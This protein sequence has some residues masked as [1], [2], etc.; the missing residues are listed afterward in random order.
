MLIH[1]ESDNDNNWPSKKYMNF[2]FISKNLKLETTKATNHTKN[3]ASFPTIFPIDSQTINYS[4]KSTD[5]NITYTH[6]QHGR[7]AN[8][9]KTRNNST[10]CETSVQEPVSFVIYT[11]KQM[12]S[13]FSFLLASTTLFPLRCC[14]CASLTE[15]V[16]LSLVYH[17][18]SFFK[19]EIKFDVIYQE[20]NIYSMSHGKNPSCLQSNF[21]GGFLRDFF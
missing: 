14:R 1:Q 16:P 13:N 5:N 9:M 19:V 2:H 8:T 3:A 11:L 7:E 10:I 12:L 18:L 15:L 21:C 17:C 20:G 4:K 6:W